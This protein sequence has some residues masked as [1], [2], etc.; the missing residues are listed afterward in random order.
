MKQKTWVVGIIFFTFFSLATESQAQNIKKEYSFEWTSPIHFQK[1]ENTIIELLNFVGAVSGTDFPTLP[2]FSEKFLVNDDYESYQYTFSNVITAPFTSDEIKLIPSSFNQKE[3]QPIIR[4]AGLSKKNYALLSFI[5]II[6]QGNTPLKVISCTIEIRPNNIKYYKKSKEIA[7]SVLA[8]GNWYKLGITKSGIYKVTYTDFVQL[9]IPTSNISSSHI[10]LFGNGGGMLPEANAVPRP[11]DLTE[12]RIVV[13][14]GGDG[15]FNDGD[16]FLFYGN[17]IH[18]WS[19][20]SLNGSFKHSFNIYAEKTYYYITIDPSIGNKLRITSADNTD[21]PENEIINTFTHYDFYENDKY[22]FAESG[23]QWFDEGFDIESSKT[24]NF[25]IPEPTGANARITFSAGS[26]ISQ[27][28]TFSITLNG[29]SIS[30]MLL[31]YIGDYDFI[32]LTNKSYLTPITSS[33][34]QINMTYN[35]PQSSSVA[36][37]DY[38][39]FQIPS[40]LKFYTDQFPFCAPQASRNG[41]YT[42]FEMSNANSLTKVWDITNPYEPVQM[43]GDLNNGV[44]SF[45]IKTEELKYFIAFNG[46]TYYS[47]S[48]IGKINNQNLI[49]T[50][51]VDMIIIAYP[52]FVSEAKRHAENRRNSDGLSILV[53]TPEQVYNEFSSGAQDPTAIR[54]YMRAIYK[55]TDG[56][57]PKYLL[58]FGRPS[59]DYR[60]LISGTKVYVPNYQVTNSL[61]ENALGSNDDYFSLLDDNEGLDC[62]GLLDIAVGRFPITTI[63]QATVCVNKTANYSATSNLV[64]ENSSIISNFGDWRN[65]VTFVGDDEDDNFHMFTADAGAKKIGARYPHFNIDKIYCDAFEQV[66]FAGGQRYPEVNKAINNR[67]DRGSLIFTYAGHGGGNG[68]AHE[69]ILEISDINKWNNKYNQTWMVN[70]TCSFGWIDRKAVSPSELIFIN[71]KGGAAAMITTTRAAFTGSNFN[72]CEALFDT[73]LYDENQKVITIGEFNRS[74]K[75][76][77]EG[78][79]FPW[80]MIVVLGDPSLK[81]NLPMCNVVTDSING[82]SVIQEV[83]TIKAL[84][85]VTIKGHITD[86]DGAILTQFNGNVFPS[87]YDKKVKVVTLRN[88]PQEAEEPFEFQLQKN[89]LFKGNATVK[90]GYFEF[91]FIVPKDINYSYGNGKLS[92]YARSSDADGTGYNNQFIIGGISD[93]PVTDDKGPDINIFLNSDKF[94][95]GGMTNPDPQLIV[96]LKDENGINTT[97]NGIGHDLIAIID[98]NTDSQIILNDFYQANQDSFN[99]GIVRYQLE[100]LTVGNHTLKIRAWDIANN[101]SE[102]SIDFTVVSDEKLA[103]DHVLNYPNPFTTHTEFY[104][105]HNQPGQL[106]DIMVQVFTI[107]GKLVKTI[108]SSQY[109]EGTRSNGIEWNGL[110]DFGDKLAKGTYIYKISVRNSSNETV[111]KF[112]KIVIL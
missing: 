59:Y 31:S 92:Y 35:K 43:I 30:N 112:E 49:G 40:K 75:N 73:P 62:E 38:I 52:E 25:T 90:N 108:H 20:D 101:V 107:S 41:N 22:N 26:T 106:L 95:T 55:K 83:D 100:E 60:G 42:K 85:K 67:M 82:V 69:R 76:N 78:A 74:G 24:Y 58:L 32:A 28:S 8:T 81:L 61:N 68:L 54:D 72:Y 50:S 88:D 10:A 91:S 2:H 37:L 94:V 39:E 47:V 51:D 19:Y 97:G 33:P 16:Y 48:T 109:L 65:T 12:N 23:K 64:A 77:V 21:Q 34:L 80:N 99:S 71:E 7:N 56:A 53:V 87:I 89:I 9:G 98:E 44:F 18:S 86:K 14:D 66:S 84:D 93:H 4:T 102:S 96:K 17:G 36:Y 5:P 13:I 79:K 70:L 6:Y 15:I 103:I 45:K 111:E 46:N 27:S 105:E 63:S 3:I 104:F 11:G 110:D 57:Y 1:D 29:N